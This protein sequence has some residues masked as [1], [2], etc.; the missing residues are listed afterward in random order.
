MQRE[1]GV[2]LGGQQKRQVENMITES[3]VRYDAMADGLDI[4]CDEGEIARSIDVSPRIT[5]EFGEAENILGVEIL[6]A[7]VITEKV[8]ASLYAKQAGVL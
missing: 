1:T 4:A 6:R 8:I 3:K 5:V 2:C 7:K